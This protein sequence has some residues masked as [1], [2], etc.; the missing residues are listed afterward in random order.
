VK[1]LTTGDTEH[2]G[3]AFNYKGPG[4]SARLRQLS[5]GHLFDTLRRNSPLLAQKAREMGYLVVSFQTELAASNRHP[6]ALRDAGYGFTGAWEPITS[7]ETTISTRRFNW[8][9]A[10]V[11]LSATGSAL[12]SPVELM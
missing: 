1:R 3:E 7:P 6:A 11:P 12:P 2:T 5:R 8:R 9:P 4:E 10:A